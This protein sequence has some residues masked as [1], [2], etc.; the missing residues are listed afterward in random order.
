MKKNTKGRGLTTK[1]KLNKVE[2][3][4]LNV[5]PSCLI[6][7]RYNYQLFTLIDFANYFLSFLYLK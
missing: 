2:I 6:K 5:I 4:E 1:I 3:K 7:L